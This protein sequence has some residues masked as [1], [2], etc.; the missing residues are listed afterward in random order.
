MYNEEFLQII[1]QRLVLEK[2]IF[3][4]YPQIVG[5]TD[6]EVQLKINKLILDK[7]YVLVNQ[8][9]NTAGIYSEIIGS[10]EIKLFDSNLISVWFYIYGYGRRIGYSKS[11]VNS[12]TIDLKVGNEYTLKDMFKEGMDYKQTI[13][14]EILNQLDN[15]EMILIK[16]FESIDDD[17]DYY[18]IKDN[19]VIYQQMSKYIPYIG[20]LME[21]KIPIS[22]VKDALIS[23]ITEYL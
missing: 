8:Q 11:L 21:F 16:D 7:V 17:Q 6:Y 2:K 18:L 23:S 5:I 13:N 20:G 22:I 19:I 12:V 3:F 9:R 1:N 10:Y 15:W 14:E 4:N